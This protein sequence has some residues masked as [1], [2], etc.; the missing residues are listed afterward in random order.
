MLHPVLRWLVP[1]MIPL[2][3]TLVSASESTASG[4][5]PDGQERT[6]NFNVSTSGYPPYII[7]HEDGSY[8][9][10]AFEVVSR[11]AN[12]LGYDLK[13][14]EIPRKR[15]DAMLLDGHIDASPRAREWTTE[16]S[17]FLFTDAMVSI[18]EVFFTPADSDF[19]FEGVEQ[20]R[21][22]TLVTPLGYHYPELEPLFENG[23]IERYEV[24]GDRDIFTYLLHGRGLDAAVADL[25]VGQWIIRQNNWHGQFRHSEQALSDYGYRLMLRPDWQRFAEDFNQEL[26][27][28]KASGELDQ[29]LDQYR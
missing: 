6:L 14:Y 18:R 15:V 1:A 22:V 23:T 7:H 9:G 5:V 21:D 12:R 17:E 25:G 19:R 26:A 24:S 27:K 11:V 3:T 10:I 29:I 28:M 4:S 16:P 13:P 20:L 8:G 2:A